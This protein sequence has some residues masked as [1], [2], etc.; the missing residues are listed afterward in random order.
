MPRR[1]ALPIAQGPA[2]FLQARPRKVLRRGAL[3]G[4]GSGE[5]RRKMEKPLDKQILQE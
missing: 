3:R 5:N 1:V 2:S 4:F